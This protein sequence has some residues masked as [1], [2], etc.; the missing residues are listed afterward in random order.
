MRCILKGIIDSNINQMLDYQ[1]YFRG[2]PS[3]SSSSSSSRITDADDDDSES[4]EGKAVISGDIILKSATLIPYRP[5]NHNEHNG[6]ND[7]NNNNNN[8]NANNNNNNNNGKQK[9]VKKS[10]NLKCEEKE[11]KETEKANKLEVNLRFKK[12][13]FTTQAFFSHAEYFCF[14]EYLVRFLFFLNRQKRYVMIYTNYSVLVEKRN[15]ISES[16]YLP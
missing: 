6:N 15:D 7:N 4:D 12:K 11:C 3:S 13:Y 5:N 9:C 8:N 2:I 10:E 16:D 1:N 14:G